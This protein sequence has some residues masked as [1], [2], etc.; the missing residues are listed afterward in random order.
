MAYASAT[1]QAIEPADPLL[2]ILPLQNIFFEH[3]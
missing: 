1:Q 2:E 3:V